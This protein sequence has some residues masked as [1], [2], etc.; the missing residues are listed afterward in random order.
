M[1]TERKAK[2]FTIIEV[3][4]VVVIMGIITTVV[5]T[6]FTKGTHAL[7]HGD[8]HNTLQR[9][10]RL[11]TARV[12]PYIASAFDPDPAGLN[13]QAVVLDSTDNTSDQFPPAP[14][15]PS[16]D[17][18]LTT[19][20]FVTTEDFLSPTYPSQFN[21]AMG[22]TTLADLSPFVYQVVLTPEEDLIIQKLDHSN[23]YNVAIDS[24]LP[25]QKPLFFSR[26]S[27]RLDTS[28]SEPPIKF[29]HPAADILVLEVTLTNQIRGASGA[30][31]TPTQVLRTTF[32]LPSKGI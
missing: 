9:A 26:E 20:R 1:A 5:A 30:Q 31:Q 6:M 17:T 16:G 27:A 25:L 24:G 15:D 12:T 32:N 10:H 11:L 2:G 8:A 21:S 22:A 19:L 28:G 3:M 7:R 18:F 23:N 29:Y 13:G 4:V 14:T